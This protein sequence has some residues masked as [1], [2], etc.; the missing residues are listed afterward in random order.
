MTQY[1][2]A[3]VFTG[4]EWLTDASVRVANG[5]IQEITTT[6]VT[7]EETTSIDLEGDYLDS[8]PD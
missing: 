5:R 7:T 4:D 1:I 8:G 3:T 2:N 6:P